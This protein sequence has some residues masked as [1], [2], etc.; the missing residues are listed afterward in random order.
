MAMLRS[1]EYWF[2][3]S[4]ARGRG[5]QQQAR[6]VGGSRTSIKGELVGENVRWTGDAGRS[7]LE[8][9]DLWPI[10]DRNAGPTF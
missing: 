2:A 7:M 9:S 1:A 5:M 8:R 10:C 4:C 6:M 3:S